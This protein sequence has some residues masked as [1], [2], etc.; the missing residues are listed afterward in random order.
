M[1]AEYLWFIIVLCCAIIILVWCVIFQAN[2]ISDL[3]SLSSK[4]ERWRHEELQA[5]KELEQVL[6][7]V[8]NLMPF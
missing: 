5:K 8:K 1:C 6:E 3:E 4:Y 7:N 2:K